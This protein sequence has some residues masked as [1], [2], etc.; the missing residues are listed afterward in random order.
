MSQEQIQR[1]PPKQSTKEK[2]AG[3]TPI[4]H[5]NQIERARRAAARRARTGTEHGR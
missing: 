4:S 5:Q 3:P 2:A 1:K